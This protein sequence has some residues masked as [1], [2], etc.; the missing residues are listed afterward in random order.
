MYSTSLTLPPDSAAAGSPT[1][2]DTH[3]INGGPAAVNIL[4]R[5]LEM[6]RQPV[7]WLIS[8]VLIGVGFVSAFSGGALLLLAGLAIGITLFVRNRGHR[9][10]WPALLYGAGSS[11]AFL[12]LPFVFRPSQCT[13]GVGSGCYRGF[14]VG[15]FAVALAIA[16]TGLAFAVLE[17]RRGRRS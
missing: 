1:G 13:A 5:K 16:V 10:G 14:T 4:D 12:L 6:I 17:V 8:G 9:R 15:T 2:Q 11:A 7:L 3:S